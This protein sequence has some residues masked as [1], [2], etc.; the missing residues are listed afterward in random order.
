MVRTCQSPK[1]SATTASAAAVAFATRRI[2]SRSVDPVERG[3]VESRSAG[4]GTTGSSRL[5][6]AR[7]IGELSESLRDLAVSTCA[8]PGGAPYDCVIRAPAQS[9]LGCP[10]RSSVTTV[11][12]ST[13][14]EVSDG[15]HVR[16]GRERRGNPVHEDEMG[17]RLERPPLGRGRCPDS[18]LA[19]NQPVR[20]HDPLRR[21]HARNRH[22][23]PRRSHRG[24]AGNAAGSSSRA[25][26]ASA[27][28]LPCWSGPASRRL[29]SS[30]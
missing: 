5:P 10:S 9:D 23:Q 25:C 30:T 22:R 12:T 13:T 15:I 28:G 11:Q 2:T 24:V 3:A 29:L 8:S 21:L 14:R 4:G 17:A 19:R 26:S 1:A 18:R 27:S 20:A 7:G 16:S 6:G